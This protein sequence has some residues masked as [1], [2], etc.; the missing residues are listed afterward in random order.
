[1]RF[2]LHSNIDVKQA[3]SPTDITDATPVVSEILDTQSAAAAALIIAVGALTGA[4]AEFDVLIEHGDEADLS[5]ALAVPDSQLNGTEELAGFATA[6]A[7]GARKIGYR[8]DRRYVRATLTRTSAAGTASVSALWLQG[9]LH[10]A[11]A[12]NPPV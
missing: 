8:G 7:N 6:D 9:R 10:D 11:P 4:D 12:P 3:I 5:D 1:M 2:D